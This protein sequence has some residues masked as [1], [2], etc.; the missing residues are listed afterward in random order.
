MFTIRQSVPGDADA[1]FTTWQTAVEATHHFLSASDKEEIAALVRDEYIPN[2]AFTVAANEQGQVIAFMGLTDNVIDSLFVH[3]DW[4]GQGI[5]RQLL[6][7][8]LKEHETLK[9]DVNEQNPQAVSFYKKFGFK[10]VGRS[11]QDDSGRPYPLLH[12]EY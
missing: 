2:A 12:L 4:F 10:E 3:S 1:L 9:L 6:N 11:E 5:G 8:A 7:A